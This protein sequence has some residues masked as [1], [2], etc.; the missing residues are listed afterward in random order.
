MVGALS[1]MGLAERTPT[2]LASLGTLPRK[3]ERE[4]S[5]RGKKK[6]ALKASRKP[7]KLR[8]LA[9]RRLIPSAARWINPT[10]V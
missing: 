8:E 3:R 4:E 2:R 6:A 9:C 10:S 5:G 7:I 1:A